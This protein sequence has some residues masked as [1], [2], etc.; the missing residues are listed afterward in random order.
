[1]PSIHLF[2]DLHTAGVCFVAL[3]TQEFEQVRKEFKIRFP[4]AYWDSTRW[5]LPVELTD[6]ITRFF[7]TQFP[8]Y[9]IVFIVL[10]VL[11]A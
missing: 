10:A 5:I 11:A 6:D 4:Q 7:H 9:P 1:M 8:N 3:S 2:M